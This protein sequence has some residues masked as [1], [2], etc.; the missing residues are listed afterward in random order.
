MNQNMSV[1]VALQHHERMDGSG[2]PYGL[3]G[4]DINFLSR[5]CA[6]ADAYDALTVD[7]PY[8]KR[9]SYA[10]AHEYLMGNAGRMFDVQVVTTMVR[11]IAPYPVGETVR[12]SSG[13]LAV[14]VKLNEGLPIRPLVR[15]LEDSKGNALSKPKDLGLPNN[16]T[17]SIVCS[18]KE[19]FSDFSRP[20]NISDLQADD[21]LD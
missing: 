13:E 11:H 2:Y 6:C 16:L 5:I 19:K 21:F 18:S 15:V 8:R 3:M 12:L 14:V 20:D 1:W 17:T 10:E 7:R 9:F 4:D